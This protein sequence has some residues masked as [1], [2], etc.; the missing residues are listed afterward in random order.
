MKHYSNRLGIAVALAA[1]SFLPIGPAFAQNGPDP[2]ANVPTNKLVG[3]WDV[4]V[5]L[6]SCNGGP[7]FASFLAMHKFERGGTGQVVPATNPAALSAHT[8]IWEPESRDEYRQAVKFYRFDPPTGTLLGWTVVTNEITVNAAGTEFVATGVAR[9]YDT[10]GNLL[11]S[12][13]PSL[14]GTRFNG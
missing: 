7:A 6:A 3:L 1:I 12:N 5:S 8:M 10:S 4:Q 9:F 11:F 2:Q 14:I 13:C